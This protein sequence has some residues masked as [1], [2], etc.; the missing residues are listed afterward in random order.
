MTTPD[1]ARAEAERIWRDHLDT[2]WFCTYG[3]D[4]ESLKREAL[5]AIARAI[6]EARRD[7]TKKALSLVKLEHNEG[8][9]TLTLEGPFV[10][11]YHAAEAASAPASK[12]GERD[13]M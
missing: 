1:H 4:A 10:D 12:G 6:A 13:R 8:R 3:D 2:C 11:A 5:D 9:F 7:A